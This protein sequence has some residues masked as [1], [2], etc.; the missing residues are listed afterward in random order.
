MPEQ[1]EAAGDAMHQQGMSPTLDGE[2]K[3]PEYGRCT[4]QLRQGQ[5]AE[6]PAAPPAIQN[7]VPVGTAAVRDDRARVPDGLVAQSRDAEGIALVAGQL[8]ETGT[9]Q[10]SGQ[11]APPTGDDASVHAG[12]ASE[13]DVRPNVQLFTPSPLPGQSPMTTRQNDARQPSWCAMLGHYIQR[14]VEVTS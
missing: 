1:S 11:M 3:G 14:R 6:D 10:L 9:G 13:R 4:V 2:D 8:P 12:L 7:G 5:D